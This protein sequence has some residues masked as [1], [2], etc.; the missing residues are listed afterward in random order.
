MDAHA[1]YPPDYIQAGV[2]RL[3][4]G[5]VDWVCGPQIPAGEGKWSRRVALALGSPLGTA[6][7]TKWPSTLD[8]KAGSASAEAEGGEVELESNSGVFGGV[9]RR[10]ALAAQGG[11]DEGWPLNQDSELLARFSEA[12]AKTV[13][14]R[15]MGAQYVPRNGL[16]ALARQYWRYGQYREKTSRH[17]PTSLRPVH[18]M[19]P[20][21]VITAAL[22]LL[23]R[24]RAGRLGR[25]GL[26]AYGVVVLAA[27]L[28]RGGGAPLR[29]RASLPLVFITMH[30]AWGAGYLFGFL[31]FGPPVAAIVGMLRNLGRPVSR[32]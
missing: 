25:L 3:R 21:L 15:K 14:L 12:G 9:W 31:R 24:G 13:Q 17:H 22:G 26:L 27:S 11:W 32:P 6:G 28:K 23:G 19:A 10:S 8:A 20:G 5:D 1:V 29:D 30:G 4:R 7:S 18:L 2:E 16:R